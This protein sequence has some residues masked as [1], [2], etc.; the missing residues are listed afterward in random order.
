MMRGHVPPPNIFP[1][2]ALGSASSLGSVGVRRPHCLSI[3]GWPELYF[4]SWCWDVYVGCC[5]FERAGRGGRSARSSCYIE[6]T[7][8]VFVRRVCGCVESAHH[9]EQTVSHSRPIDTRT[10][11]HLYTHTQRLHSYTNHKP[12]D[13][14]L[15][16]RPWSLAVLKDKVSVVGPGLGLEGLV[17][18]P[19][20][21]LETSVLVNITHF[22]AH[23]FTGDVGYQPMMQLFLCIYLLSTLMFLTMWHFAGMIYPV[24][25]S[26]ALVLDPWLSLRTKSQSLVLALALSL[27][28][29]LT[30]LHKPKQ[31]YDVQS[32]PAV[33]GHRGHQQ[34][35]D[36][37]GF[38]NRVTLTFDRSISGSLRA[39][40]LPYTVYQVWCW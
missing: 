17:L 7:W 26:L 10:A 38:R 31:S 19:V 30:S 36:R 12:S 18:G 40:R 23:F 3:A 1:R 29:L 13:V 5:V 4:V 6:H 11:S 37:D 28:S 2:T 21:G 34:P 14:V 8:T 15:G 39:E 9:S 16:L 24:M 20:L 33:N 22:C 32:V 27:E 25:L 35:C